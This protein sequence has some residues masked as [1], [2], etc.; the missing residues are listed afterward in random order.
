MRGCFKLEAKG[1]ACAFAAAKYIFFVKL[2][3]PYIDESIINRL[4]YKL[5]IINNKLESLEWEE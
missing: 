3:D 4:Q 5:I 1:V 2:G